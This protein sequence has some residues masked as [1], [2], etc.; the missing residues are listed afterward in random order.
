MI[1]IETYRVMSLNS[2]LFSLDVTYH[3]SKYSCI[4]EFYF[5][6]VVCC[7]L[8]CLSGLLA[9]I[10]RLHSKLLFLHPWMGRSY[11]LF[12]L[13]ATASSL[14]IH[15][16]GL[17]SPVLISF[18]YV[19]LGLTIGWI[20]IL[21][22]QEKNRIY[23]KSSL[24]LYRENLSCRKRVCSLKGFHGM[25]MFL[26]WFNIAGRIF[27][28]DQSGDFTC[29]T[30][31]VYKP[32]RADYGFTKHMNVSLVEPYDVLPA[33]DP[34]YARLPWAGIEVIWSLALGFGP[35]VFA[36]LIGCLWSGIY[37]CKNKIRCW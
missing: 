19:I 32:I 28:S 3:N 29:Y 2:T 14:L 31:P 4:R 13:Y 1:I 18:I 25:F 21:I 35:F 15:N 37:I 33:F 20:L 17:P 36:F 8:V 26:S 6:H 12:M 30:Y 16:S 7:Y 11:L 23:T 9:M 34:N 27:A 24:T 5:I 22:H 10:T